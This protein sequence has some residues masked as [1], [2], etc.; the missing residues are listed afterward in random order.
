MFLRINGQVVVAVVQFCQLLKETAP[1]LLNTAVSVIIKNSPTLFGICPN[2]QQKRNESHK[3]QLNS[4]LTHQIFETKVLSS[5]SQ[6]S[7]YISSNAQCTH[8][9]YEIVIENRVNKH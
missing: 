3:S 7:S 2:E 4:N 1:L 9:T 5:A 8:N 6:F